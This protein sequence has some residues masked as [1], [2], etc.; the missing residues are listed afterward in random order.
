[1]RIWESQKLSLENLVGKQRQAMK[2]MQKVLSDAEA[3]HKT[4]AVE[5]EAE[6]RKGEARKGTF[7]Y[8]S[9]SDFL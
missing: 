7:S 9:D 5:L 8:D 1:V 6:K 4:M 3:V 2:H